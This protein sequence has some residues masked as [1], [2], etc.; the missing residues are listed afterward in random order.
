MTLGQP[1]P[2]TTAVRQRTYRVDTTGK[3]HEGGKGGEREEEVVVGR[4]SGEGEWMK[5]VVMLLIVMVL[6]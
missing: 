5:D 2:G 3:G 6:W 4:G 1:R